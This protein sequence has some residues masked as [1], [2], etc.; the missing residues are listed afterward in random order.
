MFED[1]YVPLILPSNE[2]LTWALEHRQVVLLLVQPSNPAFDKVLVSVLKGA[3][4]RRATV[5]LSVDKSL[6]FNA[7]DSVSCESLSS[8]DV[9]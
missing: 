4:V 7:S 6:H 8:E 3:V 2:A 5:A 9:V 1:L